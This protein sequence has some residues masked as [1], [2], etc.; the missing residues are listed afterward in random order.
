MIRIGIVCLAPLLA[1]T[2]CT[3][4]SDAPFAHMSTSIANAPDSASEARRP[5]LVVPIAMPMTPVIIAALPVPTAPAVA[6]PPLHTISAP[7]A[8]TPALPSLT[9]AAHALSGVASYYW[10]DQMTSSGERFDKRAMTAAHKTLPLGTKVRVTSAASGRSVIVRIN[11]RGPF[12]GGRV[13]D[14]SE[15]AAEQLQMTSAGLAPVKIEDR[16]STRLNSS[17]VSQSRMPSSA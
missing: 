14:L 12:K 5:A 9:G 10:Q 8:R 13:I 15:A 3:G 1:L 17:H 6:T 2:G 7:I 16:K 11:D 4:A